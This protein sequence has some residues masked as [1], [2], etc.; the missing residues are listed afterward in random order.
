MTV[1]IGALLQV[2]KFLIEKKNII[3]ITVKPLA[4]TI[5]LLRILNEAHSPL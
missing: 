2:K 5:A 3:N 1:E 4:T